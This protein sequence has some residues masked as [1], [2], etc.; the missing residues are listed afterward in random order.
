MFQHIYL[1][2]DNRVFVTVPW[3]GYNICQV[4]IKSIINYP[5]LTH[6]LYQ[7][8]ELTLIE[9]AGKCVAKSLATLSFFMDHIPFCVIVGKGNHWKGGVSFHFYS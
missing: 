2:S 6:E 5:T 3:I 7:V 4:K 8:P 9:Y 1:G